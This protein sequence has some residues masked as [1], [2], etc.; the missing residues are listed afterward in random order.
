MDALASAGQNIELFTDFLPTLVT[1]G[2]QGK[3]VP[4]LPTSN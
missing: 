3:P 2:L 1:A 4:E